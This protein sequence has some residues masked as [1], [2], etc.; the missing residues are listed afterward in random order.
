MNKQLVS[1]L[2]VFFMVSCSSIQEESV[3]VAV[4]AAVEEALPTDS[5]TS[6]ITTTSTTTTTPEVNVDEYGVEILDISDEMKQQLSDLAAFVANKVGI[7]YIEEPKFQFYTLNGYQDY[8]ELSYLDEFDKDYEPGE[9][10]RVVLSEQLWGLTTSSPAAMKQLLVEFMR[11]SS[12]GSYNLK[13]ELIRVPVKRNQKKLNLWERSVL[14][15]ELVHTLQGQI[16]DLKTWYEEM[17]ELDDQISKEIED[18]VIPD[19]A[20]IDPITG[21]PLPPEGEE[22]V[23]A[24]AITAGQLANDNKVAEI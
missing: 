10:E 11:C 6:T 9:W 13:D 8:N 20:A 21:E 18:G 19:P 7:S 14:V 5:T 17:E 15:H 2:L 1:I 24:D 23:A 16:V 4:E 12:A 3:D 22:M